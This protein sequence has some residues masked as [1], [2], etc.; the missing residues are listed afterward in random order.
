MLSAK[1]LQNFKF[2]TNVRMIAT[3]KERERESRNLV[4]SIR[5]NKNKYL[6]RLTSLTS[7]T[8]GSEYSRDELKKYYDVEKEDVYFKIELCRGI[9]RRIRPRCKRY[10]ASWYMQ[11]DTEF[12][13]ARRGF[14]VKE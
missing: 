10:T 2:M 7:L 9:R 12:A 3:R 14:I 5:K 4:N 8:S 13:I 1:S 11:S 6:L